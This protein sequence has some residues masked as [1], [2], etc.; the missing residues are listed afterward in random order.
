MAAKPVL[1]LRVLPDDSALQL[2]VPRNSSGLSARDLYAQLCTECERLGVTNPPPYSDVAAALEM[3]SPGQWLSVVSAFPPVAPTDGSLELLVNVPVVA[4]GDS[5]RLNRMA[6]KAG[7]PL[8][9]RHPG[10][11]GR[12]GHDLRR[13]VIQPRPPKDPLLPSGMNTTLGDDRM[14][15]VAACDGEAVFQHMRIDVFPAFI[16]EGDV[17]TGA[18]IDS[19]TL[20]IF[21]TGSVSE[22]ARVTANADI[23]V[24]GSVIE[25]H[26]QSNAAAVTVA[27][28]VTG[29]PA[30]K[31]HVLSA[32]AVT[33]DQVRLA[34]VDTRGDIHVRTQAWQCELVASGDLYLATTMQNGLHHVELAVAG[35][36]L[37]VLEPAP[38]VNRNERQ[39]IRV[40]CSLPAQISLHDLASAAYSAG[41]IVDI[42]PGGVRCRLNGDAARP[43]PGDVLQIKL[44]LPGLPQ[45]VHLIGK[46]AWREE[47]IIG[48]QFLQYTR[49]DHD[50][51]SAYCRV[52]LAK[53]PT[54]RFTSPAQ[55]RQKPDGDVE[56]NPQ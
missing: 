2:L 4:A 52:L 20:P 29:S 7:T 25:A 54:A 56:P 41:T 47:D 26:L 16:H 38:P 30:K 27:G 48:V 34:T 36:I 1:V 49:E 22:G 18:R 46:T 42:S 15:L 13:G 12:P 11:P 5:F 50:R 32:T 43:I 37:P 33:L 19:P 45:A 23:F 31:A 17:G 44:A 14:T 53:N 9:R 39:Y 35:H 28:V 24:K 21:I 55:R 40:P 51:V 6:V 3:S 8:V 10:K